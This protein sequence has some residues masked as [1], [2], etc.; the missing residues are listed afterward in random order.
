MKRQEAESIGALAN[1]A[2]RIAAKN[3]GIRS[4]ADEERPY[5]FPALGDLRELTDLLIEAEKVLERHYD[6]EC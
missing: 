1:M 3:E 6:D 4:V 5:V 2:L